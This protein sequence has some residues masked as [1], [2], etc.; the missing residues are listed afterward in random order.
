M[1]PQ[2]RFR[3]RVGLAQLTLYGYCAATAVGVA[4]W[5]GPGRHPDWVSTLQ[6]HIF[7]AAWAL[8]FLVYLLALTRMR[9]PRCGARVRMRDLGGT[10]A[11]RSF[12]PSFCQGCGLNL[13]E[14]WPPHAAAEAQKPINPIV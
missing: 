11:H 13:G 10:Y 4:R 5:L 9:C 8:G 6:G 14:E 3:K 1:T 12:K 7:M 2:D